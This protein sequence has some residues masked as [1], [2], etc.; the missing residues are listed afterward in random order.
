MNTRLKVIICGGG[1]AGFATALLL[2]EDHDVTILESST[3]NQ[4]LGAA[5]TLSMNASRLLRSSLARAGFDPVKARYIE[6]E[7]FQEL[8]WEDLSVLLEWEMEMV[9]KKYNEPWW[10]FSRQDIHGEL[11]RA[12][13]SMDGLGATPHLELGAHV[14][15][16]EMPGNI[17]HLKDGRTFTSDVIIGADG[18]RTETGNSVFGQMKSVSQGLS[19]YRCM[20]PSQRMR[21]DPDTAMLVDSAKVLMLIGPDRRIVAYPCSS[22]EFMNFVCIFPDDTERRQQWGTN[23]AVEDVAK[24]LRMATDTGVWS[25]RDRNPLSTLVKGS[26]ALIGDA[27]HAM[28]PHQGQGGCQAIEDAEALRVVLKG[29]TSED[30]ERRLAIFDELRVE[31]VNTVIEYTREMAPKKTSEIKVNHKTTQTYSD[32][33]WR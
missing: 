28:G 18:I 13:L 14:E 23:V 1:I 6:A 33:Y 8:H 9:T 22:W 17:V 4:E 27:A 2:R 24:F 11:K 20:I 10:Y 21:K 12:A 30:V 32:Y 3:L 7:K 31:Q 19:A 25:L 16:V 29:A 26:F 15:R 5:I